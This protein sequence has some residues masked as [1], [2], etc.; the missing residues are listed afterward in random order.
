MV[1]SKNSNVYKNGERLKYV[2]SLTLDCNKDLWIMM[3]YDIREDGY[4]EA[5]IKSIKSDVV[6]DKIVPNDKG[7]IDFHII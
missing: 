5:P 4:A 1:T 2:E 6:V 7:G 3:R